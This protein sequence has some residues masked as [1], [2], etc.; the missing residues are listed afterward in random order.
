[1]SAQALEYQTSGEMITVNGVPVATGDYSVDVSSLNWFGE[2]FP[3]D[4]VYVKG[5]RDTGKN[6]IMFIPP[7]PTKTIS[8]LSVRVYRRIK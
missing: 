5:N 1:M 6:S 8:E 2:V 4:T 7:L 3:G